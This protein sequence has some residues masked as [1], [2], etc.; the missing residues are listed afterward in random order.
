MS[1]ITRFPGAVLIGAGLMYFLDPVRGRKRRARIGEL[2]THA[3]RV[4]RELVGKGLRDA[5]HRA[6]GVTER[7]KHLR[8]EESNDPVLASRVRAH[9]GRVANA[10]AI[11]VDVHDG[12]VVLRGPVETH[13]AIEAIRCARRVPGVRYVVDRLERREAGEAGEAGAAA[14]P[15]E[16]R[17]RRPDS[18]TPAMRVSAIGLGTA[19][20]AL[21]A[22]ERGLLGTLGLIGGGAL[23]V[24]GITNRRLRA[25]AV[26]DEIVVQKTLTVNAPID[27]VYELW[28]RYAEFPRFME[29]VRQVELLDGRSRWTVDGPAGVALVFEVAVERRDGERIISW[30]SV[31]E[32][33]IRHEGR[34]RFD[35]V[36][37]GTRV[38]LRMCYQPPG[39]LIGHAVAHALRWDPKARLDDDMIRMKALLENGR[40]RAHR[41]RVTLEEFH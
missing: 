10:H 19:A 17:R 33:P 37:G 35:Q 36:D 20:I 15:V 21:G 1:S 27:K 6:H 24:R 9:L 4:E 5:S 30:R 41:A 16:R 3:R 8:P 25:L 23:A 22:V 28:T 2:A 14:P 31:G 39:G 13:Q 7:L 38:D 29:H 11:E 12:R 26:R 32:S 40:T 34:V 18:W